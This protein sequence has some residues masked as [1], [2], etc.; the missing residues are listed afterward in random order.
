MAF[1]AQALAKM[2]EARAQFLGLIESDPNITIYGVTS[3]YGQHARL[4]YTPA[5]RVVHARKPPHGAYVAFGPPLPERVARGIVFARL[6]NFVEGHAAVGPALAAAVGELLGGG[7]LPKVSMA[8]QGGAGEITGLAPLFCA[9]AERFELGEKE[10]L[11]LVNGSPCATALV[12]D[13]ALAA[14][15]R[16]ELAISAWLTR[17][18]NYGYLGSR[19]IPLLRG[20]A[21]A[22]YKQMSR[23][24]YMAQPG[25]S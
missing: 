8:G 16:L 25:R 19:L 20:G 5:E 23:Y 18:I 9:V 12:A 17:A 4:R 7:P 11:S 14:R 22:P 6:T 3:G 21:A 2:A 1:S 13:A 15:R 24:L 10:M